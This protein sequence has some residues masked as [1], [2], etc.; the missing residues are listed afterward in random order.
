MIVLSELRGT[1]TLALLEDTVEVAEIIE[2]TT[3]T[4][5]GNGVRA[6]DEH[7]AGIA[8]TEVND[9]LAEIATR[10]ELEIKPR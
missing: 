9:I 7:S 8:Q 10:V 1:T 3:E 4:D 2:T 6:V 5:L